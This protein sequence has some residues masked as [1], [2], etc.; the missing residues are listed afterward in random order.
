MFI[1]GVNDAGDKLFTSVNNT[2][3]ILSGVSDTGDQASFQIFIDSMTPAITG[4]NNNGDSDISK[5]I[6][7]TKSAC[8]HL[9][10]NIK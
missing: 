10:V 4:N 6:L 7:A 8:L 3:V 2:G 5:E 9:K 1:V